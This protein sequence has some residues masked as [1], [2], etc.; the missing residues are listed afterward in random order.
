MRKSRKR[1]RIHQG[2]IRLQNKYC[3]DFYPQWLYE[4]LLPNSWYCEVHTAL[5]AKVMVCLATLHTLAHKFAGNVGTDIPNR[6]V[7]HC[8]RQQ[9]H[10]HHSFYQLRDV[11]ETWQVHSTSGWQ[12]ALLFSFQQRSICRVSVRRHWRQSSARPKLYDVIL[13]HTLLIRPPSGVK[14]CD[15]TNNTRWAAARSW[16]VLFCPNK[17]P[18][19]HRHKPKIKSKISS[20]S[21]CLNSSRCERKAVPVHTV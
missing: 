11:R 15:V 21:M 18:N 7:S 9:L 20:P 8:T 19:G 2:V 10:L 13:R 5:P 4:V 1:R 14:I 16:L 17:P 12:H 3:T 6:T